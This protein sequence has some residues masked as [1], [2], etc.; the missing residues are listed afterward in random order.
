MGKE[1]EKERT[2]NA[3]K[4]RKVKPKK[5]AKTVEVTICSKCGTLAPGPVTGNLTECVKCGNVTWVIK[6]VPYQK[7]TALEREL[8][9]LIAEKTPKTGTDELEDIVTK[10]WRDAGKGTTEEYDEIDK[11]LEDKIRDAIEEPGPS[12]PY[13]PLAPKPPAE[14]A[15]DEI[16]AYIFDNNRDGQVNT[17]DLLAKVR[18]LKQM[19]G[20]V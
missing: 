10:K 2:G 8:K 16:E 3:P 12:V 6:Q 13:E 9:K 19:Y 15:L 1:E 14:Q 11:E 7:K 4:S 5:K 18:S 17:V 20:S